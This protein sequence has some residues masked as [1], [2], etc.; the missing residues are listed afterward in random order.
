MTGVNTVA[1]HKAVTVIG[2]YV[3]QPLERSVPM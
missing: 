2:N 3:T 1:D